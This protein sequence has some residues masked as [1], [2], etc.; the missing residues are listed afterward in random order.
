MVAIDVNP[1]YLPISHPPK[2]ATVA[3]RRY[4]EKVAAVHRTAI[5]GEPANQGGFMVVARG[6]LAASPTETGRWYA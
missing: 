6:K 3:D 5:R 2:S 4:K 1:R